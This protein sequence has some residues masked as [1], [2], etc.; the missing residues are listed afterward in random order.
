MRRYNRFKIFKTKNIFFYFLKNRILSFKRPKWHYAQKKI[1]ILKKNI[2]KFKNSKNQVLK[3]QCFRIR[4]KN[5]KLKIKKNLKSYI[6]KKAI[7]ILNILYLKFKYLQCKFHAWKRV[8]FFF[9]E[10]LTMKNLLSTYFDNGFSTKFYKNLFLNT[11]SREYSLC[12]VFVR[13]EYRLDIVLWRLQIASSLYFAESVIKKKYVLI[14]GKSVGL[15]HFITEGDIISLT[16]A[17]FFKFK[18]SSSLYI[19][20]QLLP[21]Y[22]EVDFYLGHFIILKSWHT[23]VSRDL[24]SIIRVPL[25]FSKIKNY[26]LH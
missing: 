18:K 23:F 24:T 12:S 8:R 11:Y 2:L 4:F 6:K 19:F 14:N 17:K 25:K 9:K 13:P 3:I 20:S 1:N 15:K 5:F 26:Y 16:N 21:P 10:N 22:V 7:K